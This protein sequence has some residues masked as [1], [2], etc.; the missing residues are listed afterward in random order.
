MMPGLAPNP[1]RLGG[2]VVAAV[3]ARTPNELSGIMEKLAR[4]SLAGIGSSLNRATWLE[5]H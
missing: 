4:I 1:S 5:E 2:L 3:P